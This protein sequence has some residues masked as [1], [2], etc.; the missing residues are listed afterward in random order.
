MSDNAPAP[1]GKPQDSTPSGWTPEGRHFIVPEWPAPDSVRALVTTRSFGNLAENVD[2]DPEMLSVRR[3]V[4]RNN[5][6]AEPLWMKQVHETRCVR[7][8]E[9]HA[10]VQADASIASSPGHVCV[11]LTADCLPILLCDDKGSVVGAV[12]AGWR[13]LAA[14]VIEATIREMTVPGER[15][16]AWLGPAIGPTAYEVGTEVMAEF[17]VSDPGA[18]ASFSPKPNGKWLC[19]LYALARR[20]L[21]SVGV[22][23]IYGGDLCTYSDR[24]RFYSYRRD[25]T[26]GRMASLIWIV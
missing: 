12:H 3:E 14:G 1:A 18:G 2:D 22:T 25:G 19:N 24:N 17:T 5:L 16:M 23:R 21:Q 8:E 9:S 10:N 6:P 13:G 26:T 4:L 11:V 15:L 7:A 20:R